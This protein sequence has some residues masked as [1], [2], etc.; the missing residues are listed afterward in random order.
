ML[1]KRFF[2]LAILASLAGCAGFLTLPGNPRPQAYTV[3]KGDTLYS[4]AW[5]YG[6]DYHVV[7]R[8]NGIV[9]PYTIFPGERIQL[10]PR[11]GSGNT[12]TVARQARGSTARRD[13]YASDS[14]ADPSPLQWR[15]PAEGKAHDTFGEQGIAGKG[16]VITGELGEPV[17]AAAAGT[18]VYSGDALVGYGRLIIVKHNSRWLSAYAHNQRLLAQE[19][20]TVSAGEKIATMG[21]GPEGDPALYFE[22]R[23]DGSP[24]NPLR[25]LAS[26]R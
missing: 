6:L 3:E 13:Q 22:I 7:A 14:A 4:I 12:A 25:Y 17:R 1:M 20:E 8:W 23:K 26:K 19:G 9:P 15:W 11:A 18:V 5:H 10:Y 24:V 2:A 21:R 16:I